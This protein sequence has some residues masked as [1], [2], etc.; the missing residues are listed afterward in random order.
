MVVL[1]TICDDDSDDN[2]V[3]SSSV[4]D[5]ELDDGGDDDNVVVVVVVDDDDDDTGLCT[6][7]S[8][9]HGN[10]SSHKLRR[11]MLW[12]QRIWAGARAR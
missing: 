10:Q 3:S 6:I 11:G 12:S 5:A 4:S 8:S 2:I 1:A 9:S 7:P